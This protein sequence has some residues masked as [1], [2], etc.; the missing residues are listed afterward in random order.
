[1]WL[2]KSLSG[3][4]D[5]ADGGAL[6]NRMCNDASRQE[7]ALKHPTGLVAR[8]HGRKH[9]MKLVL[10]F[11]GN[12]MAI[13]S[14]ALHKGFTT[15]LGTS[16]SRAPLS[17]NA[18]NRWCRAR[19]K[20][21]RRLREVCEEIGFDDNMPQVLHTGPTLKPRSSLHDKEALSGDGLLPHWLDAKGPESGNA[22]VGCQVAYSSTH[23]C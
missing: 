22:Y 17:F 11:E 14:G 7:E 3:L 8:G 5:G 9:C 21:G 12:P 10:E 1:M 13:R 15:G 19:S 20:I 6:S 4:E 2:E 16:H 18:L 23:L